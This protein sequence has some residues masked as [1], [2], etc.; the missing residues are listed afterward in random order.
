MDPF[1]GG[2]DIGYS[3]LKVAWGPSSGQPYTQIAPSGGGPLN[4]LVEHANGNAAPH[5]RVWLDGVE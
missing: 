4:Q 5:A 1:V 3:N 2:L